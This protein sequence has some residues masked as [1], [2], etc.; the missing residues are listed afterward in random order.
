MLY[1]NPFVHLCHCTQ[2]KTIVPLNNEFETKL[3]A[4]VQCQPMCGWRILVKHEKLCNSISCWKLLNSHY[5]IYARTEQN[6]KLFRN[7]QVQR[8]TN[9]TGIQI[10]QLNRK[11]THK[12]NLFPRHQ[13]IIDVDSNNL[14]VFSFPPL[15]V[16]N[17]PLSQRNERHFLTQFYSV[18]KSKHLFHIHHRCC[19]LADSV[20]G[21]CSFLAHTHTKSENVNTSKCQPLALLWQHILKLGH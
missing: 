20:C 11:T 18:S 3:C 13:F 1:W 6:R 21:T 12:T 8:F 9:E 16:N 17:F 5:I 15:K 10:S 7:I 2:T 4:T 19:S 14:K